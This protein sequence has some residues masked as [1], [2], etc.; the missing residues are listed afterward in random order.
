MIDLDFAKLKKQGETKHFDLEYQL[1]L[2]DEHEQ[3]YLVA[4]ATF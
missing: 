3:Y 1:Q 4:E 2:A